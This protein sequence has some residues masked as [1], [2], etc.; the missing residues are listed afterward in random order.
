MDRKA[1]H[2]AIAL[3]VTLA[4][5]LALLVAV[6]SPARATDD[7]AKAAA[8]ELANEA[9]RDFDAGRFEDAKPKFQRAYAVARVPTLA[10]WTARASAKCGQLVAASELYRQATQLVP[11]D[12]WIGTAQQKAQADA[13]KELEEL[14][15]RIPRLRIRVEGAASDEVEVRMDDVR[16]SHAL[17]GFEIPADPGRRHVVGSKGD[18]TT[19]QTVELREGEHQDA[20]LTFSPASTMVEQRPRQAIKA[21]SAEQRTQSA[22]TERSALLT[23]NSVPP[24][25]PSLHRPFYATWWF[26]TGVGAVVVAG[27]VTA[28][29]LTHSSGGPCSNAGFPCAEV[30]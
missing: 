19:E 16:V 4:S 7:S 6:S 10:L 22:S 17:L 11:N 9:K 14:R 1:V 29:V 3:T 13:R 18:E 12:L 24:E 8:R 23:A 28:Y 21:A 20:V 27:G 30:K 25:P 5:T 15:P 26:W 2:P